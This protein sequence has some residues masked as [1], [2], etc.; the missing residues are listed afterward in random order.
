MINLLLLSTT[1][2]NIPKKHKYNNQYLTNEWIIF[3]SHRKF[4]E[5]EFKWM[6]WQL[7]HCHFE[8]VIFFLKQF[9]LVGYNQHQ[10]MIKASMLC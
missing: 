6:K 2:K 8:A 10:L 5:M 1:T 9:A 3:F 7:H 4:H